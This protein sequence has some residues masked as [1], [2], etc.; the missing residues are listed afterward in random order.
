MRLI[1]PQDR[2]PPLRAPRL[3]K[4]VVTPS[5]DS[6]RMRCCSSHNRSTGG[7]LI[8]TTCMRRVHHMR[9][10]ADDVTGLLIAALTALTHANR[11]AVDCRTHGLDTRQSAVA[12]KSCCP[13]HAMAANRAA[14]GEPDAAAMPTGVGLA[15]MQLPPVAS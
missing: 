5:M 15:S 6:V 11:R 4:I 2:M 3:T 10:G 13:C 7:L 9:G 14:A 8:R 1:Q 12:A